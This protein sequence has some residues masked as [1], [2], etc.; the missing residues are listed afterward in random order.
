MAFN[1]NRRILNLELEQKPGEVDLGVI[2]ITVNQFF[3]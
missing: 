1:V 3:Y 2:C